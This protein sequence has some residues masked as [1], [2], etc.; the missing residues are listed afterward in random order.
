MPTHK[1]SPR[2]IARFEQLG[3]ANYRLLQL[4]SGITNQASTAL[5]STL[6]STNLRRV[7]S[8]SNANSFGT[9]QGTKLLA[10][11]E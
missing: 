4:F 10:T 5:T 2:L 7:P 1:A 6:A 8:F 9:V 3:L 11:L